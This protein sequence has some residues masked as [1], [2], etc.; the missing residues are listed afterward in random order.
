M[1]R[2]RGFTYIALLIGVAIMGVVLAAAGQLWETAQKREKERELL[3]IGG[4]F[5]RAIAQYSDRSPNP[6]LRYPLRL[7]DLLKD[8]R[9]PMPQRYLR[10]IYADPMTGT[11]QWG[12]VKG[13]S[14]E[15][16]GV[17][18]LSDDMPLKTANFDPVDN[19]FEGRKKYSEWV[20]TSLRG[21]A[22]NPVRKTP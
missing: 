4:E 17:Y 11:T 12:L 14:G 10:K 8:P 19:Q 22:L 18:S 16:Y 15:I 13:A 3:F 1:R 9:Y 5:R 21:P 7:E 2:E 6:V 20:F